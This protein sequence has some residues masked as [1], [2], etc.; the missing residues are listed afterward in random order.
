LG[1]AS[2][3]RAEMV[4][5]VVVAGGMDE[6]LAGHFREESKALIPIAGRPCVEHVLEAVRKSEQV[7]RVA[8]VG[9]AGVVE[10]A[11]GG[12]AECKVVSEGS[13]VEKLMAGAGALGGERKLLLVTS[14]IPLVTPAALEEVIARCPQECV[15]FHPL[16]EKAAAM[17]NFPEHKWVFIKLREG[18]VV[19]T[20]VFL[21]DAGWLMRRSDLARELEDLRQ[22]PTRMARR[23]GLGFL[24]KFKLGLLSLEY[25][26]QFFSRLLGAP[27]R[28]MICRETSLAMDLDRPED[29]G[30]L[31]GALG[32]SGGRAG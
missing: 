9:P 17:G 29:V 20:N 15:F 12:L 16:V 30:M 13:I 7:E 4:N 26:E 14:D 27:C 28:G 2:G 24:A 5:A 18:V 3:R 21:L 6:R 8:L 1:T 19:T 32:G 25:C 23:F 22:H 11:S 10:S 31:E